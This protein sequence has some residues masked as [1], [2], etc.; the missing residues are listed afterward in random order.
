MF[1]RDADSAKVLAPPPVIYGLFFLAGLGIERW[2]FPIPIIEPV[3]VPLGWCLVA[4]G[5]A[6]IVWAVVLFQRAGTP[7]EPGRRVE[8][9]VTEGPYRVSRNP[10][11]LGLMSA[12]VGGAVLLG[13]F[14]PIILAP[15]LKLT[16][17]LG[18]IRH[19]ERYLAERFGNAYLA[20][21]E[22]TPRWFSIWR[23]LKRTR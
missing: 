1:K 13:A 15:I 19:E 11:Y 9:I 16:M 17:D 3:L 6:T 8:A 2:I 18:V 10:I 21:Y 14:W 23:L 7:V 22:I 20:F 5:L 12:Y 4:V